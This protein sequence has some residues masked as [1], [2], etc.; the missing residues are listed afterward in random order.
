MLAPL[1]VLVLLVKHLEGGLLLGAGMTALPWLL[2]DQPP[3]G[4]TIAW[5]VAWP[6]LSVAVLAGLLCLTA[7]RAGQLL[8]RA[9]VH[10]R[11]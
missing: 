11:G 3:R 9:S 5:I 7:R 4:W 6:L 1:P 10:I 2:K 8:S